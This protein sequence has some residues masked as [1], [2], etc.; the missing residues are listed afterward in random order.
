MRNGSP[1]GHALTIE[2]LKQ[3][4]TGISGSK[5]STM[6]IACLQG[7]TSELAL[8]YHDDKKSLLDRSNARHM[9]GDSARLQHGSDWPATASL[10]Y[11]VVF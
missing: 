2:V 4:L 7:N 5:S 9:A 6:R 10:E 1:R 11:V 8:G 3:S